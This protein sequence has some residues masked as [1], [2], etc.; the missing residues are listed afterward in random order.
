MSFYINASDLSPAVI[1]AQEFLELTDRTQ[2]GSSDPNV[3]ASG[4]AIA[5]NRLHGLLARR[6]QLPLDK[7]DAILMAFIKPL[8]VTFA[9][10]GLHPRADMV[11]QGLLDQAAEAEKV[12]VDIRDGKQDLPAQNPP[13]AAGLENKVLW[14][15]RSTFQGF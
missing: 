8:L 6:Y 13:P 1:P 9:W 2:S 4:I 10:V 5:E 11:V 12:L 15:Q 3:I 7:T 14:S